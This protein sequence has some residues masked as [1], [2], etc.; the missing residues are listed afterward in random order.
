MLKS[1]ISK[2]VIGEA[3]LAY[4][5]FLILQIF[6]QGMKLFYNHLRLKDDLQSPF[7]LNRKIKGYDFEQVAGKF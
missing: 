5:Y 1:T 2:L 3:R 6:V 7:W 4:F